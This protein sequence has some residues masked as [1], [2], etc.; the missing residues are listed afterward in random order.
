LA[1]EYRTARIVAADETKLPERNFPK[2][3]PWTI[4][5]VL[6]EGFSPGDRG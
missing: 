2:T 4:E 5:Q 3:C 1:R 6:D